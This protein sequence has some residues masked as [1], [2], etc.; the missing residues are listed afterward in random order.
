M[1]WG[2]VM[3]II[4]VAMLLML[5]SYAI[6]LW[7][8]AS[9]VSAEV[10]ALGRRAGQVAEVVGSLNLSPLDQASQPGPR[11]YDWSGEHAT[12]GSRGQVV[13]LDDAQGGR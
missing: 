8:K 6:W 10:A 1:S 11:S 2:W 7:H 9:D 4:A 3:A 12:G 5:V 13:R